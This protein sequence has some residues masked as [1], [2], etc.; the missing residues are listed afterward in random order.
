VALTHAERNRRYRA[1][2]RGDKNVP[3]GKPG[4]PRSNAQWFEEHAAQTPEE[5]VAKLL[6]QAK[7]ENWDGVIAASEGAS[8]A[9]Q[10]MQKLLAMVRGGATE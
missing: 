2:R 7:L 6:S 3:M 4:R 8:E 10:T 5:V 9:R 1:R